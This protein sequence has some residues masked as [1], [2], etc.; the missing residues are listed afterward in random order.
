VIVR[1]FE[2]VVASPNEGDF[3]RFLRD[4][5]LPELRAAPGLVYAKVGR[6]VLPQGIRVLVIS[7]WRTPSALYAWVGPDLQF[8]RIV[9]PH[10]EWLTEYSITH[11]EALDVDA[12]ANG[13]MEPGPAARLDATLET[14]AQPERLS[15]TPP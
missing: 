9:A 7:E 4:E 3:V 13:E 12:M 6:Q 2:G 11:Y 14:S 10:L 5:A 1:V 8:P 15:Q